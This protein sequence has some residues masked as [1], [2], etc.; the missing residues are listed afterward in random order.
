MEELLM[1]PEAEKKYFLK[2]LQP[3]KLIRLLIGGIECHKFYQFDLIIMKK[4]YSLI[5]C[6]FVIYKFCSC[7]VALL[8]VNFRAGAI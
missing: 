7:A 3:N 8:S 1:S 6:C 2:K 4:T 5:I